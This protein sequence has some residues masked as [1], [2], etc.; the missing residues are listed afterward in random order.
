MGSLLSLGEKITM[1]TTDHGFWIGS[2]WLGGNDQ[3]TH[4]HIHYKAT[5]KNCFGN[6]YRKPNRRSVLIEG[7]LTL[8]AKDGSEVD[9]RFKK[10]LRSIDTA[11]PW[12]K[13][14]VERRLASR[15]G[16]DYDIA[17]RR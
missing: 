11:R 14:M 7:V 17:E 2:D 8:I 10:L 13:G 4:G 16:I 12:L 6:Q 1:M 5:P 3:F 9:I 15:H